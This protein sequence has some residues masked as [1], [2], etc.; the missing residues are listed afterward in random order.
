MEYMSIMIR[1]LRAVHAKRK[2]ARSVRAMR[3]LHPE[4]SPRVWS[5]SELQRIGGL[6]EGSV[7]NV[8][9]WE[10]KDKQGGC[11]A[12]Y[13]PNKSTYTV[14]NIG[15]VKGVSNRTGEI[16]IDLERDIDPS[17]EQQFDV[18]FNHTTLEHVFD[19]GCA[20]NVLCGL[21]R[22]IVI[23]VVPFMQIEHWAVG[24]Y[25]DYHRFTEFGVR[26]HIEERG[27]EIVYLNSN[28]NPVFPIYYFCVG[29]RHPGKWKGA[30]ENPRLP[31]QYIDKDGNRKRSIEDSFPIM[32]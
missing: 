32:E 3:R 17:L 18:V 27:F 10:D 11:Y 28:H 31:I 4:W 16:L 2:L 9:G 26:R 22:D 23:L 14:S 8:S 21:S 19:I 20:F 7:I 15:G 5:N 6:F 13:F 1:R 29:S 25:G 12:D 24:S 30:M